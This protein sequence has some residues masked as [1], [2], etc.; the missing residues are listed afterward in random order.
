[1]LV[2][3]FLDRQIENMVFPAEDLERLT[4]AERLALI[5]RVWTSLRGALVD[6]P[7]A[8]RDAE[9][10]RARLEAH[11]GAPHLAI[12]WHDV[13]QQFEQEQRDDESEDRR[14]R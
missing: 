6:V 12:D 1:M 14:S 9:L 13:R 3:T 10:V 4:V 2:A 11:A 8:R 7:I 5:D